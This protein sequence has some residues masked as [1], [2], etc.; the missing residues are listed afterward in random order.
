MAETHG[1]TRYHSDREGQLVTD[2]GMDYE[3]VEDNVYLAS[4]V[5]PLLAQDT[6]RRSRPEE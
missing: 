5:D 3:G 6:T 4:E 2:S 1:L